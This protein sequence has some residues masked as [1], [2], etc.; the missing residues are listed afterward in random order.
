MTNFIKTLAPFAI[1]HGRLNGVLPS[2]ILAQGILESAWGTSD[3][4]TKANNLFGIKAS[5]WTGETY[6]KRTAEQRPDGSV[7]YINADFRS[8]DTYEGCV[9]D[10][11]H[12]YTHGTGWE[13][14][15]RY[16]DVLNQ[17]DYKR[18]T[19][20]VKDAGYATDV[21]YP[22]KLNKL[23]EQHNLT[24]YD[25]E[26]CTMVKIALDAGHGVNTPGKR[27]PDGERE[28]TFNNCVVNSA[29]KHL[30][31]YEGVEV[32]RL[33]DETGRIDV[34]LSA[35][36]R[37]ANDWGAHALVSVHHNANTGDW[38]DWTGTETY[39]Y[40]AD[41]P[42]SERLAEIVQGGLLSAYGLRNRGLKKANFH[43]LRESRMPAILTEGGYMDSSIDIKKLRDTDVLE[44][45]GQSIAES[46][47]EYFN[48]STK[49]KAITA[50]Q[51]N[52][53]LY[54]AELLEGGSDGQQ[55]WAYGM[56]QK[57]FNC[58]GDRLLIDPNQVKYLKTLIEKDDRGV[59]LWAKQELERYVDTNQVIYLATLL[60][61]SDGQR[62]WAAAQMP[63]Y[64]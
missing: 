28:W 13:D 10:L 9:I 53:V 25:R 33:D 23:I 22:S 50:D 45:A 35:R 59:R 21:N 27:T 36:T 63:K 17:A 34:P 56:L 64:L 20:A 54:W 19:Q 55:S 41:V 62:A 11:C 16:E 18:A 49:Q 14:F 7:Y 52:E 42:E 8:Y 40:S 12:K 44:K 15:N 31:I 58:T 5:N 46:V 51:G 43:M 47:A 26:V 37:K 6:T 38:G 39:T 1:N 30:R 29:I 32:L 4:A 57:F 24:Q 2:L 48:L 60:K 61:E 3:L